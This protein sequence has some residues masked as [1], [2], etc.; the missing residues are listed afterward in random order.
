MSREILHP[1]LPKSVSP[2]KN[3]LDFG[4]IKHRAEE[5]RLAASELGRVTGAVDVE[6]V[7]D[8]LFSDFCIGK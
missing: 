2:V 8:V 7:L 1:S 4:S 3:Q 6:D 5:L